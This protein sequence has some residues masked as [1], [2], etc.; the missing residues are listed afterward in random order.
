ML[1]TIGWPQSKELLADAEVD[2]L[3]GPAIARVPIVLTEAERS[4]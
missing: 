1:T 4:E 3:L 2:D